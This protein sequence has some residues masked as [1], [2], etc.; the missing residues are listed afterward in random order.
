M[1]K[2]NKKDSVI[3]FVSTIPQILSIPE[4]MPALAN[5]FMPGWWKSVPSREMLLSGELIVTA[6]MCPSFPDYF[7]NGF[8]L[9]AWEDT[10]IKH[11]PKTDV[12]QA[13]SRGNMG[14]WQ[15]H[16]H[17]QLL[18]HTEI[19]YGGLKPSLVFKVDSPWKIITKPGWSV[20]QL[21]LFY[22]FNNDFMVMPG[23][24][25]SD[26]QHDVNLQI[27]YFGNNK[28]IVISRGQPLVQ[29]VPFKRTSM[30]YDVRAMGEGDKKRFDA[31]SAWIFSK[32]LGK[33]S[34]RNMQKIRDHQNIHEHLDNY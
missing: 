11:N 29:Y 16:P 15:I 24:V 12:W 9:P 13:T 2:K 21:P 28:D 19:A 6:K 31:V 33:G 17:E 7:S 25:D 34:Y 4:A 14:K 8:I 30:P 23:I 32:G 18:S 10:S 27:L 20:L 1:F 5:N 3:S 22:H 26:I